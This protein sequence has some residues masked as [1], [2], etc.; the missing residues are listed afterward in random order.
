MPD[1]SHKRILFVVPYEDY[2][3]RELD[4]PRNL[5]GMFGA[6]LVLASSSLGTAT[7]RSGNSVEIDCLLTDIK[8]EDYDAVVF[9][10]GVGSVALQNNEDAH[11]IARST[12][13]NGKILGA[14]CIAPIILAKAGVL[15]TRRATVW[16]DDHDR[17][18]IEELV[19]AR[20]RYVED[21]VVVDGKLVTANGPAAAENFAH[22]IINL[23]S[24]K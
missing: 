21:E 10:G 1:L 4:I 16:V 20:A 19:K 9:V 2:S 5:F 6:E 12:L 8:P 23:L 11:R 3:E 18:T 24:K 7:G 14:I 15:A 13:S 17:G 22:T